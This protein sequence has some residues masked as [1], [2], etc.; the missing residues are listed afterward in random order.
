VAAWYQWQ[1]N[2]CFQPNQLILD[3]ESMQ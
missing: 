3:G 1:P 2:Q